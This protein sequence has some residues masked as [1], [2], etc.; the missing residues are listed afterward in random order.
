MTFLT[1]TSVLTSDH[2]LPAIFVSSVGPVWYEVCGVSKPNLPAPGVWNHADLKPIGVPANAVA[3]DL[4]GILI[5]TDGANSGDTS[6]GVGFQTPGDSKPVGNYAMQTCAVG[7]TGG[8]RSNGSAI[9]P[10]VNGCIQWFWYRVTWANGLPTRCLLNI[11]PER[12]TDSTWIS[13]RFICRELH[14][15]RQHQQPK[16]NA[17]PR[18]G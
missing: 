2:F 11:L 7:P 9:V 15:F 18:K 17:V 6:I 8:S 10:C 5:I 12:V 1:S 13:T 14:R 3:V 16:P 4:R